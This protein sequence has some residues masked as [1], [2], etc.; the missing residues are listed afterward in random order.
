MTDDQRLAGQRIRRER[1]EKKSDLGNVGDGRE[2]AVDGVLEHDFLH[3][4]L[5]ADTE[6]FRLL[7]NLFFD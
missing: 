2:L 5:F 4:V 3:H 1:C 6:R 7:G